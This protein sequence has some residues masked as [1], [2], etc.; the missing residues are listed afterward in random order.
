MKCLR[1]ILCALGFAIGIIV[2]LM[3]VKGLA[4]AAAANWEVL[5][6]GFIGMAIGG[7]LC[8]LLKK[9]GICGGECPTKK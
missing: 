7:I 2:A 5:A 9:L 6:Y 3:H 4:P 1:K 8:G